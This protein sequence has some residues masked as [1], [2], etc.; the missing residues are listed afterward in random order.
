[1]RR[2]VLSHASK[3]FQR[4]NYAKTLNYRPQASFLPRVPDRGIIPV[5]PQKPSKRHE[6]KLLAAR[7]AANNASIASTSGFVTTAATAAI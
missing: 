4:R 1:M 5:L 2:F 7:L 6:E 3:Y